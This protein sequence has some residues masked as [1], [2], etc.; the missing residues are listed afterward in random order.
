MKRLK[1]IFLIL[2]VLIVVSGLKAQKDNYQSLFCKNDTLIKDARLY[3]CLLHQHQDFLNKA[4]SFQGI[5]GGI[6]VNHQLFVGAYGSSFASNLEAGLVNKPRYVFVWQTGL[7]IGRIYNEKSLLHS[8]WQI[9]AGYFSLEGDDSNF[10]MF[11]AGN[12]VMT[13][14]GMILSPEIFAEVNI[15]KWIKFRIGLA[16]SFYSFEN[17]SIISKDDLQNIS[18]NFGFVFGKFN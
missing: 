3:G 9:K 10:K 17:Q 13:V 18:V 2:N 14:D 6:I 7:S 11:K 1:F 8:G 5:E 4:F 16:Y 15:V 12:L